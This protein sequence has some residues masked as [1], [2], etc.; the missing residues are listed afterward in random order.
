[1]KAKKSKHSGFPPLLIIIGLTLAAFLLYFT[2]HSAVQGRFQVLYTAS[3]EPGVYAVSGYSK[4][5]DHLQIPATYQ[6]A[7]VGYILSGSFSNSPIQTLTLE[8]VRHIG[9]MAFRNCE[10]L[11]QVT[12]GS[13]EVIGDN[14]FEF[15]RSL[16]TVTIPE[17]VRQVG[18]RAFS[19]C[20]NLKSM[21]F[22]ADPEILGENIFEFCP[23]IVIYGPPGGSV[24]AYCAQ[25]GLAF[26]SLPET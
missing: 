23:D 17:T 7:P 16:T 8:S 14:A 10:Q 12:L 24:E 3:Q 13:A 15:C 18:K 25:Y 26:Q 2:I 6:G 22:L 21:Y 4:H 1:M 11:T 20:Q 5:T 9:T 19:F